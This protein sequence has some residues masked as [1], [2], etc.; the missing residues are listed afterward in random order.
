MVE[1]HL[2]GDGQLN[3][4]HDQEHRFE[5]CMENKLWFIFKLANKKVTKMYWFLVTNT[6]N[7]LRLQLQNGLFSC[8]TESSLSHQLVSKSHS[9]MINYL[10]WQWVKPKVEHNP[11]RQKIFWRCLC[12]L[13][14]LSLV[15]FSHHS[16]GACCICVKNA[17]FARYS[18]TFTLTTNRLLSSINV[19][20][21]NIILFTRTDLKIKITW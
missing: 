17:I 21:T 13:L 8:N 4:V 7:S 20:R 12:S 18:H 16:P 6:Q 2:S 19:G 15:T 11:K 3:N 9:L 14:V 10:G 1:H 5:A